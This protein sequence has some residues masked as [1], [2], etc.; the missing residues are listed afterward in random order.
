VYA[1]TGDVHCAEDLVAEA[2]ARALSRWPRV[3][4][5]PAPMAQGTVKVQLSRALATLRER[6]VSQVHFEVEEYKS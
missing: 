3:S 6:L 5:H 2:Y 4:R 1:S